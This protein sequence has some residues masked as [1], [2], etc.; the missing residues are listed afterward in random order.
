[1]YLTI[2]EQQTVAVASVALRQSFRHV[3]LASWF[4]SWD[5]PRMEEAALR[6]SIYLLNSREAK[7]ITDLYTALA[8]YQQKIAI[9]D[10][11]I[12]IT[13]IPVRGVG[14]I[15]RR[16]TRLYRDRYSTFSSSWLNEQN[17][18]SVAHLAILP[19]YA[20]PMPVNILKQLVTSI[21]AQQTASISGICICGLRR[22]RSECT[23][24]G[25]II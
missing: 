6:C 16:I 4:R 22:S 2:E 1:M 23:L 15:L 14:E 3:Q 11:L 19:N 18:L 24:C 25:S 21:R 7:P 13:E 10:R 5:E 9:E 8:K 17:E 12:L 20:V